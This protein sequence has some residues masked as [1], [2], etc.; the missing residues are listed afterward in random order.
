MT[1]SDLTGDRLA[2]LRAM[3]G[4]YAHGEHRPLGGYATLLGLYGG[5]AA[6][7]LTVARRR[8]VSLS[9]RDL[10]LVTVATHRLARTLTKD[11]VTSPLRAPFTTYAGRGGP[12]E[13]HEEISDWAKERPLAHAVGEMLTCPFC[14]AQW[15]ATLL[16]SATVLSPVRARLITSTLTAVA[17]ADA[18]QYVYAALQS[19]EDRGE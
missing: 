18:L 4:R 14:L 2:S 10:A 13:V 3:G 1:L 5:G 6:T 19:L 17:G 11:A 8:D 12:S 15:I 16:V 7:L 9:T